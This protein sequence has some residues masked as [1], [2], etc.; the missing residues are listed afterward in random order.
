MNAAIVSA[1]DAP[2]RYGS[3][4]GPVAAEGE[5]GVKGNRRRS[6]SDR[7]VAGEAVLTTAAR[8][9]FPSFPESTG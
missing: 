1:Y 6:A 5:K 3:F 9:N 2:P 7:E 4:D 8:E